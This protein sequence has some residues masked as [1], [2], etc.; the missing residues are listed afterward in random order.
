MLIVENQLR[1]EQVRTADVAAPQIR[2][3]AGPAIDFVEELALFDRR[4][5]ARFALLRGKFRSTA[6]AALTATAR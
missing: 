3:V 1:A 4:R 6:A 5:I 2:A